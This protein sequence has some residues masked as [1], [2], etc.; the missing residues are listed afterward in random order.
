MIKAH[1]L[2]GYKALINYT[3]LNERIANISLQHHEQFDGKGIPGGL[4]GRRLMNMRV[5]QQ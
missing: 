1:P 5:L 3:E 4:R 2:H